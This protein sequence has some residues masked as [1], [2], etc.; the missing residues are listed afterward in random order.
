MNKTVK[1]VLSKK[2]LYNNF[3]CINARHMFQLFGPIPIKGSYFLFGSS[4]W[5]NKSLIEITVQIFWDKDIPKDFASY[6]FA[7]PRDFSNTCFKIAFNILK[8]G[9]WNSLNDKSFMLFEENKVNTVSHIS[10]FILNLEN[11]LIF[12]ESIENSDTLEYNDKT[13]DGF[14]KM[15]LV[16][17]IYGFGNEVYAEAVCEQVKLNKQNS[18]W[19]HFKFWK[20]REFPLKI[21]S[22]PYVP[23]VDKIE[24][25]ITFLNPLENG[26]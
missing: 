2:S 24:I 1:Q 16:D 3:G 12:T 4:E 10:T 23:L 17:P 9:V 19:E 6:Y 8:D 13:R 15:Q 25:S 14:I 11:N 7:Y 20:K 26:K 5:L 22:L 18:F 21:P